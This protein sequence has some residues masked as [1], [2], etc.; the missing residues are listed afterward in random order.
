M[1]DTKICL[2]YETLSGK[3]KSL[4]KLVEQGQLHRNH[5]PGV[6]DCCQHTFPLMAVAVLPRIA[7]AWA[8]SAEV[9]V[10]I[11]S[12]AFSSDRQAEQVGGD[13]RRARHTSKLACFSVL[14][15]KFVFA[16]AFSFVSFLFF[17]FFAFTYVPSFGFVLVFLPSFS[18][19]VSFSR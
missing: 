14:D 10:A 1:K 6:S 8:S 19:R 4:R 15:F 18:L 11:A 16:P 3:H 9:M 13:N 17:P 5:I 2:V 12:R 7:A